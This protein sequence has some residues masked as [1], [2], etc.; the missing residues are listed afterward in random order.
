[1]YKIY[2]NENTERKNNGI[3]REW[4]LCNYYGIERH[5]HDNGSYDVASDVEVG[6]MKISAKASGFTLM[7]GGKC[8]GCK[9]FEGIWRRY[10]KNVHSNTWAYI[11][12]NW[13]CYIMD[14][15][16]FSKFIHTFGRLERESAK[17][18][19]GLK[20]RSLKESGKMIEWFEKKCA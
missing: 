1:M 19:G 3:A 9:T 14:K 12:E 11:T 13:E 16:E 5:S 6:E 8:E 10:Y 7:S 17:N 2:L 4:A 20:I 15:K 18:G